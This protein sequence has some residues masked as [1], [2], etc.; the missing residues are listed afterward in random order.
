[1]KKLLLVL[2][3]ILPSILLFGQTTKGK[4]ILSAGSGINFSGSSE[5][6]VLN[7]NAAHESEKLNSFSVMPTLGY[8]VIDNLA[9]GLSS[10]ITAST[11]KY[12]AGDKYISNFTQIMPVAIYYFPMDGKI[13][14]SVQI[15][16]G[17]SSIRRNYYPKNYSG[18]T[19]E[20]YRGPGFNLGGG[21][22]Y[23]ISDDISFNFG[24]SYTGASM[25]KINSSSDFKK[26]RGNFESNFGVSI[27]L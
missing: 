9:V 16:G 10:N 7:G 22:S 15:G 20:I 13:R 4:F 12:V 25:K 8:F 17:Y 2:I 21:V 11:R 23:F 27:F 3:S 1:M 19:K 6:S 14:P 24:L 26:N 18:D 5:K